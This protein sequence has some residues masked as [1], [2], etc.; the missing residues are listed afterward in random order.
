MGPAEVGPNGAGLAWPL[1]L[2]AVLAAA[3]AGWLARG[4]VLRARRSKGS[5]EQDVPLADMLE[6]A[7]GVTPIGIGFAD[8]ELR[9]VLVNQ[10]FA[11]FNG[12]TPQAHV[13]RP[14]RELLPARAWEIGEP[15]LRRVLETGE[16]VLGVHIRLGE[17][18]TRGPVRDFYGNI[19]PVR[20]PWGRVL[21]VGATVLD[22]T[23]RVRTEEERERL[24]AALRES[25]ARFRALSE[26][27]VIGVLVADRERLVEANDAFLELMWVY[28]YE[29]FRFLDVNQAAIDQYGWTREEFLRMT[30]REIRPP[31]ELAVFDEKL[32]R[33]G[34]G[35]TLG[36][37]YRHWRKDGGRI[38]VEISSQEVLYGGMRAR[39]VLATDVTARVRMQEDVQRFVS[40]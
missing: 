11:R 3:G 12:L 14:V 30:I 6:S 13:G 7:L 23:A 16:P 29:S 18:G 26:S 28:D 10:A 38:E 1:A 25:E 17:P 32:R 27:G 22:V 31:E 37:R 8:R 33:R 19:F 35:V 34:R 5:G 20:G 21:W 15:L 24:L 4:V 2:L 40:L 36:G 39:L 9:F